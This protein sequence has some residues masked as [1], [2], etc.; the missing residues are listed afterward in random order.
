MLDSLATPAL[1]WQRVRNP[2][3][4]MASTKA[5]FTGLNKIYACAVR[6]PAKMQSSVYGTVYSDSGG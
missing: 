1:L 2:R 4:I 5:A 3:A 6:A